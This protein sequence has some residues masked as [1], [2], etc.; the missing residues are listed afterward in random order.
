MKGEEGKKHTSSKF[1]FLPPLTLMMASKHGGDDGRFGERAVFE[2]NDHGSI[3]WDTKFHK[4]ISVLTSEITWHDYT[5]YLRF[6]YQYAPKRHFCLLVED[7]IAV[8]PKWVKRISWWSLQHFAEMVHCDG[9]M[10]CCTSSED[11]A[12]THVANL[13]TNDTRWRVRGGRMLW[14]PRIRITYFLSGGLLS[15]CDASD[16]YT[17]LYNIC[18]LGYF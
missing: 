1:G 9:M 16:H 11:G 5:F 14:G 6:A 7:S 18:P 12:A 13:I 4:P 3:N 10:I 15:C 2:C 8:G 17:T